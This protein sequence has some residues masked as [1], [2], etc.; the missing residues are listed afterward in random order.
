M[1]E[2]PSCGGALAPD[3]KFC[4][5]CGAPVSEP[6]PATAPEPPETP[7]CAACGGEIAADARFCGH[8]G[9]A[10]AGADEPIA[11]DE[12]TVV[13]E[14]TLV[15]EEPTLVAE[16]PTLVARGSDT[17]R[18]GVDR[19]SDA[20]ASRGPLLAQQEDR[21]H[22]GCRGDRRCDRRRRP[23]AGRRRSAAAD[24]ERRLGAAAYEYTYDETTPATGYD[25]SSGSE[26]VPDMEADALSVQALYGFWSGEPLRAGGDGLGGDWEASELGFQTAYVS[27][28]GFEGG[29]WGSSRSNRRPAHPFTGDVTD[30]SIDGDVA[31]IS[32]TYTRRR[33]PPTRAPPCA[34]RSR[35]ATASSAS[36]KTIRRRTRTGSAGRA[37]SNC[38]A[39][40]GE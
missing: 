9:A 29:S 28:G 20:R 14:P 24:P 30:I 36:T 10:V 11:E 22:R 5:G 8:C 3:D 35:T 1:S 26:A 7:A 13:D 2:C 17:R 6:D 32:I 31:T 23:V 40:M 4:A 12:P 21:H 38:R 27:L 39:V 16:E 37:T 15:A 34:Y 18:G 25:D 19:G 33:R